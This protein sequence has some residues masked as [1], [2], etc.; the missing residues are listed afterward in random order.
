MNDVRHSLGK[1]EFF[2]QLIEMS[3]GM[4]ERAIADYAGFTNSEFK[5]A[6][7][8]NAAYFAVGLKL[9]QTPTEG[10]DEAK[11]K[12]EIERWNHEH[13]YD[14]KGFKPVKKVDFTIPNY[15]KSEVEEGFNNIE[16][17]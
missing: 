1:E 11:L 3:L 15:I 5:E 17:H 12:A 14:K 13:P 9:L 6:A 10:Y 16:E 7:R 2:N 4:L 8:R